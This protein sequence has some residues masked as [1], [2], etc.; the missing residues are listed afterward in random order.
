MSPCDSE[1]LTETIESEGGEFAALRSPDTAEHRPDYQ[2]LGRFATRKQAEDFFA[3][4]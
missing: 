2:E 1:D 4:Q 3:T